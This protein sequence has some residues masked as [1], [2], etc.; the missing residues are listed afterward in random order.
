MS[1]YPNINLK[2]HHVLQSSS[3]SFVKPVDDGSWFGVLIDQ[4]RQYLTNATTA[5]FREIES[6]VPGPVQCLAWHPFQRDQIA[7]GMSDGVVQVVLQP[8]TKPIL[9]RNQHQRHISCV[10]WVPSYPKL[11]CVGC[12]TG[13]ILWD[14]VSQKGSNLPSRA[15]V[16]RTR[17]PV[18]SV[19]SAPGGRYCLATTQHELL[20]LDTVTGEEPVPIRAV[21]TPCSILN[22]PQYPFSLVAEGKRCILYLRIVYNTARP[23]F[24]YLDNLEDFRK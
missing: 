22:S 2:S 4:V 14:V 24:K 12:A 13:I 16:F 5:E 19:S 18:S 3:E 11:L 7:F 15:S 20:L 10:T 6:N 1:A 8:S 23:S 9:L 21:S 17:S